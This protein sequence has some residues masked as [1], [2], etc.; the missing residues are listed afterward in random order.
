MSTKL[1]ENDHSGPQRPLEG[2]DTFHSQW[3]RRN[4]PM[5]RWLSPSPQ[6]RE[7]LNS[8]TQH[9]SPITVVL[10]YINLLLDIFLV[11]F[12]WSSGSVPPFL[13]D[14]WLSPILTRDVPTSV[15]I[16]VPIHLDILCSYHHWNVLHKISFLFSFMLFFWDFQFQSGQTVIMNYMQP[17]PKV[18]W[19]AEQSGAFLTLFQTRF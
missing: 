17:Q 8:T 18:S 9:T 15:H 14:R 16:T 6:L 7:H 10:T 5:T 12:W 11:F 3:F 1:W 4:T 13:T 2:L 19:E